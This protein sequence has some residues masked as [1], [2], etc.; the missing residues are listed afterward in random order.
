MLLNYD[1]TSLL[2]AGDCSLKEWS[3][4]NSGPNILYRDWGDIHGNNQI[5]CMNISIPNI[6]SKMK[7]GSVNKETSISSSLKNNIKY[8]FK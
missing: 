2:V 8:L 7:I 4:N 6:D 5:T 3:V 1:N